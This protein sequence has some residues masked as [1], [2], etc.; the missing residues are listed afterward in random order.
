MSEEVIQTTKFF[1]FHLETRLKFQLTTD[2]KSVSSKE[3]ILKSA[4]IYQTTIN[5]KSTELSPLY[6]SSLNMVR[7][8][9]HHVI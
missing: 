3:A 2:L 4:L 1:V 5:A 6:L 9:T 7:P 8:H